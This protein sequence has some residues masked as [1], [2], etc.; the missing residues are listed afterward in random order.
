MVVRPR[1]ADDLEACLEVL[2]AVRE[3][4]GYP[5]AWPDDRR[6]FLAPPHEIT[7]AVAVEGSAT[8]GHAGLHRWTPDTACLLQPEV[9]GVD[10]HRLGVVAR[11]FVAP[12]A[13]RSGAGEALLRDMTAEAHRRSLWP[14]LDVA[15][16]FTGAAALYEKCGWRC[17]GEE[18]VVVGAPT[19]FPTLVFIGP[20]PPASPDPGVPRG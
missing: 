12:A 9:L 16:Q 8:V 13:R 20:A 1:S 18:T 15:T 4:D 6:G 17:V 19:P 7:A 14:V 11:L 3:A 10:P 2:E 5:P